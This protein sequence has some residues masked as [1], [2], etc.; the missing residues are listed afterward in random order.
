MVQISCLTFLYCFPLTIQ[1]AVSGFQ[2]DAY[3]V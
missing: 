2:F 3:D 1:N